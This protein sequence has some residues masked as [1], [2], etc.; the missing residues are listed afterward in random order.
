MAIIAFWAKNVVARG[1]LRLGLGE[2]DVFAGKLG[3][4]IKSFPDRIKGM[5]QLFDG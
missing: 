5:M 2:F 1:Y 3:N 4:Y